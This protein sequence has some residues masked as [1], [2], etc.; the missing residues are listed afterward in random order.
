LT[1]WEYPFCKAWLLENGVRVL[2]SRFQGSEFKVPG[3][4]P[5]LA[6][7]ARSLI[8]KETLMEL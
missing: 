6:G 5:T 4:A 7:E 2:G 3:S 1:F 8:I